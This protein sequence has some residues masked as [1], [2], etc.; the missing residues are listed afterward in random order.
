MAPLLGYLCRPAAAR[1]FFWASLH[2]L[3]RAAAKCRAAGREKNV[4]DLAHGPAPGFLVK[5][6]DPASTIVFLRKARD[7]CVQNA[8]PRT[9]H[10]MTERR[11]QLRFPYAPLPSTSAEG[12]V[13]PRETLVQNAILPYLLL[14]PRRPRLSEE[15]PPAA[16]CGEFF[17]AERSEGI[18]V[19]VGPF[20]PH[21][22]DPR[23]EAAAENASPLD[24]RVWPILT[25]LLHDH[26]IQGKAV[27]SWHGE[28]GMCWNKVG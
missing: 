16:D 3:P 6:A 21:P 15:T 19:W 14:T 26:R 24:G 25:L 8:P 1:P 2:Y 17:L 12:T 22:P 28:S 5:C 23:G 13:L 11:G 7:L 4:N 20:A 10:S 27:D 9:L 18:I